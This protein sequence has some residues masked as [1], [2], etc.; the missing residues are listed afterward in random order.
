MKR[1]N[2]CV[3]YEQGFKQWFLSEVWVVCIAV[4]F[5]SPTLKGEKKPG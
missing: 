1:V 4:F 5:F 3:Y 2:A